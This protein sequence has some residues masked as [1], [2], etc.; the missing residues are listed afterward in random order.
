MRRSSGSGTDTLDAVSPNADETL[1]EGL[2][3]EYP[4]TNP[5]GHRAGERIA[6]RF[7][8]L[9]PIGRGAMG[10]VWRARHLGLDTEVALKLIS[11]ELRDR[12]GMLDRF[13]REAR[14]LAKLSHAHIVR[15][16]DVALPDDPLPYLAMELLTGEDLRDYL[17]RKGALD[18]DEAVGIAA[19][20]SEALAV[21]HRAGVVHRDL[22][23]ANLFLAK[24]AGRPE[25][26]RLVVLDFGT[27]LLVDAVDQRLT[28]AGVVVGTP[29]YMS[30]EQ[31]VGDLPS[32]ASDL[33]A[34]AIILYEMLTEH[35]PHEVEDFR[36]L[37]GRRSTQAAAPV[38]EFR[39][40]LPASYDQFFARALAVEPEARFADA[41]AFRKAL[42]P[43]RQRQSRGFDDAAF[44]DALERALGGL[45][46]QGPAAADP[47]SS[48][49]YA[50][51]HAD[52]GDFHS[53]RD[54][55]AGPREA[56]AKGSASSGADA[57][58]PEAET[59]A[60]ALELDYAAAGLEAPDDEPA[61]RTHP[62]PRTGA[63]RTAAAIALASLLA[64]FTW[65]LAGGDAAL[66][67]AA[68][69]P[70]LEAALVWVAV[71]VAAIVWFSRSGP[72]PAGAT[73][74]A[75]SEASADAP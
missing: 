73:T 10:E 5:R 24:D 21:A 34:A 49:S 67:D 68:E 62:A 41:T 14:T 61:K 33:Y 26:F 22:K 36:A 47:A 3:G 23:P 1:P 40:E 52:L 17:E 45:A 65:V 64:Y 31:A 60:P 11:D 7:E 4:S 30:P 51:D 71:F 35:V 8:L 70:M 18:A 48:A 2:S 56:R 37:V 42:E 29:L 16:H 54:G 58:G 9:E 13:F 27:A 46:E 12:P 53:R 25:G 19:Q 75:D 15:V 32:P 43:L 66:A 57:G 6:G 39:P 69:G 74:G 63:L 20:L 72:A 55:R 59:N 38:R 44:A 50:G 28:Q